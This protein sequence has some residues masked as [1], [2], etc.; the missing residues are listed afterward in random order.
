MEKTVFFTLPSFLRLCQVGTKE[1]ID[2]LSR[3]FNSTSSYDF[4]H[5]LTKAI[6]LNV[7]GRYP[8]EIDDVLNSP[9]NSREREY[10]LAAYKMFEKK[11]A[12]KRSIELIE[13]P[14]VFYFKEFPVAIKCDPVFSTVEGGN[15]IS[16][17]IWATRNPEL[18]RRTAAIGCLILKNCYRKTSLANTIFAIADLASGNRTKESFINNSTSLVLKSDLNT[19][20]TLINDINT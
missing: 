7:E 6:R 13:K 14:K 11:Y 16:H 4:Y 20:C 15:L 12:R 17:A 9:S 5:T 10:N 19:I 8:E 2:T 3:K 1:K 18:E